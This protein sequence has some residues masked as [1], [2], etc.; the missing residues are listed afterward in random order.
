MNLKDYLAI[1]GLP[2]IYRLVGSRSNGLIIEDVEGKRKFVSSRKHQF[3]PLESI[4]IYTDDGESTELKN[5]FQSM[6]EQY[7][8]NPPV[9][10]N[11]PG[12]EL[13]EYFAD[14]LPT[15][16]KNRVHI[17]DIK[18]VIKWFSFMYEHDL[19]KAD[20]ATDEEE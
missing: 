3:T 2:G 10:A 12:E 4:A 6:L 19:L 13:R 14:V 11:A 17:G 18:K 20:P 7:Q 16:D 1:S 15:F 9:A 5:V 8:D